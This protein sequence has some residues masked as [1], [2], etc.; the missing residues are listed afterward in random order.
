MTPGRQSDL[1]IPKHYAEKYTAE[2]IANVEKIILWFRNNRDKPKQMI[3][4]LAGV[5][6]GT[7]HRIL[8]GTYPSPP[9]KWLQQI[10]AGIARLET[11]DK[12]HLDEMQF[13]ET[14]VYAAVTAACK[15]AHLYRN[16]A[17][18]S[19]SVGTGKTT[20]LKHYAEQ[21]PKNVI[22]IEAEPEMNA[23][24]L[25]KELC[26]RTQAVV[27]KLKTY[28]GG[29]KAARMAGVVRALA[30]SDKLLI[31][32]E[33]ETAQPSCLE[34]IRRISDKCNIGVV[35][36]GTEKLS[37]LVRDP[38]GRFGQISSRTG[39]WPEHIKS[40][41]QN[42]CRA[43]VN[44]AFERD[45]ITIT[46]ELHD[47]FWQACGG[48]ARVLVGRGQLIDGIRDYGINKGH[49]LTTQLIFKTFN[50]LLGYKTKP[51]KFK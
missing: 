32:D 18:V 45:N 8:D 4:R 49:P 20:A 44:A 11:R 24:V 26:E 22:L 5:N 46:E 27:H 48:S 40:I 10:F 9:G 14:S 25:L 21:H 23:S 19:A 12:K 6:N 36:T 3:C 42:D 16:F 39:F 34:Y 38:E 43:L 50:D 17:V 47:A 7:L 41:N 29:S 35:L 2:D 1:Q 37:T 30:G 31:F 15:R 51:I 28:S 33:A 13:V